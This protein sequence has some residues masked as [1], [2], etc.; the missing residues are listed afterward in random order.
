[1]NSSGEEASITTTTDPGLFLQELIY[2][3]LE[4]LRAAIPVDLCAYLHESRDEG[5]QLFLVTPDLG[6]IEPTD[7]FNLF[8]ALRD[9][10]KD[11]HEG[12]ET[13]QL[14]GY[15]AIPLTTIGSVSRGLHVVG[16]HAEPFE[17]AE[18]ATFVRLAGAIGSLARITQVSRP[19]A[20]GDPT[21]PIRVA[22]EMTGGFARAEVAAPFGSEV[23]TGTGE[24]PTATGA[25]AM[26]VIDAVDA[27]M[28]LMETAEVQVGV[29]RAVTVVLEDQFGRREVGAALLTDQRDALQAAAAASLEVARRLGG[30]R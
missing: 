1:M 27:T 6:S 14:G 22:I 21:G 29:D 7:A 20:A 19:E 25:V 11:D 12:D 30:Q 23:R 2:A 18:R 24:A 3:G 15:L 5:P 8:S 16:R 4:A 17:E 26:A 10:L 13:L 9:A 28:K